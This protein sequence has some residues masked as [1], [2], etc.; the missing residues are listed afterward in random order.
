MTAW[1]LTHGLS[2]LLAQI[3]ARF[4]DRDHTSDGTIGDAAH[5]AE[6]SGHNPDDTPGSKPEWNGDSDTIPEVRALDVDS[7]LHDLA[8][9]TAQNLVDWIR[10]LPGVSAGIRY[11]IYDRIIYHERVAFAPAPY[12]GA[13]AH[14]EH[15]HFSGAWTNAGDESTFNYHLD[16]LGDD[17]VTPAQMSALITQ[18]LNTPLGKGTTTVG[19][20]LQNTAGEVA[21]LGTAVAALT[22]DVAELKAQA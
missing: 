17:D 12:T 9:V 10:A 15:I 19:Q 3:D 5:Q 16:Q 20:A 4:P 13:S 21:Q 6:V 22:A 14:T 11:M 8:G 7:D 2:N 18:L 1:R